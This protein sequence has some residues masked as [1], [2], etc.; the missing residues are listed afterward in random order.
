MPFDVIPWE[1]AITLEWLGRC[2]VIEYH[3]AKKVRSPSREYPVPVVVRVGSIRGTVITERPTRMMIYY[4]DGFKCAYCGKILRDHELT[5]D[6]VLPKS[7]GGSW[8]WENLVT[9]CVQ[10]NRSKNQGIWVPR[11]TDP[12]RPRFLFARYLRVVDHIDD[13]TRRIW[14]GYI[15]MQHRRALPW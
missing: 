15:P 1:R 11:F 10:C 2:L 6:H 13:D 14:D 12:V 4:R 7:K 5:I 8:S 3:P 9:C